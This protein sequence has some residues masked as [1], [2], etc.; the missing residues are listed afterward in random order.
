MLTKETITERLQSLQTQPYIKPDTSVVQAM[1][2]L[3][4]ELQDDYCNVVVLGEFS[5][6]KSTFVNAL[7]GTEL[8]PMNVL[9]E[10]A[11]INK[12]VYSETP[13]VKVVYRDGNEE[14]GQA[15]MS[16]LTM[17]SASNREV[18]FSRISHI[19]IGYPAE[20]LQNRVALIDTPGVEDMDQQRVDIT[21]GYLPKANA[22]IFLLDAASPLKKTELEFL[23][24]QVLPQGIRD[25]IFVAN[26]FDHIDPDE[27][28]PEEVL[29]AIKRRINK[30]LADQH[31]LG[32]IKLYPMCSKQAM[33]ARIRDDAGK[34]QASGYN[35]MEKG[36]QEL[37]SGGHVGE[38]KLQRYN[39]VFKQL[40]VTLQSQ[41]Q[42][43]LSLKQLDSE[44]LEKLEE[45][46]DDM[47]LQQEGSKAK[48][49]EFAEEQCDI[50]CQMTDKS[51][52]Y[53]HEKLEDNI[54]D[55][56]QDYK[57]T[58]FK[59]YVEVRVTKQVSKEITNWLGVYTPRI[60]LLLRK[61]NQEL[62]LGL[63]R[64]F[65]RE[66][67]LT[68][69]AVGEVVNGS[70]ISLETADLS[71]TDI[72]AGSLAAAGGLALTLIAGSVF[73]PFVSFA[74]MPL[75]R[76]KMLDSKLEA[77]KAELIPEVRNGLIQAMTKLQ[78]DLHKSIRQGCDSAAANAE[79]SYEMLLNDIRRSVAEQRE[80]NKAKGVTLVSDTNRLRQYI[81]DLQQLAV[82]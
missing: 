20:F 61:L 3:Q 5:R 52:Q 39:H 4:Q 59:E 14:Q 13:Y 44:R 46:L 25:I 50:I 38:M 31:Q 51:L 19:E 67:K 72:I 37:L 36:L 77:A 18:D 78:Q 56:V 12:L 22:I 42:A 75:I 8:I 41:L 69:H 57:G 23:K 27:E 76:R 63:S 17:F 54:V 16:Y 43:E 71:N 62:S 45:K 65:K 53:F 33:E 35:A 49:R 68:S 32:E 28:E 29:Q 80:E 66:I 10:T 58:D 6:G 2:K 30:A 11:C 79:Y 24:K 55:M 40:V 74:A 64:Q 81:H 26:K 7:L 73:M 70:S 9:Q 21:Y 1:T 48:L 34:L 47:L 60:D 82:E 15:D